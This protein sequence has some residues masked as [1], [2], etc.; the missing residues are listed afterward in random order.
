MITSIIAPEDT[1]PFVWWPL[2]AAGCCVALLFVYWRLTLRAEKRNKKPS[3]LAL[4]FFMVSFFG[5]AAFL[6]TAIAVNQ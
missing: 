3:S 5:T 2:V 4:L 6:A 1:T